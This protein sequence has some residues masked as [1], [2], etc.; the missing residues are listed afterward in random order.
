MSGDLYR[1]QIVLRRQDLHV[2]RPLIALFDLDRAHQIRPPIC[3]FLPY[4]IRV[5]QTCTALGGLFP[6]RCRHNRLL[7]GRTQFVS[8]M[9]YSPRSVLS[10]NWHRIRENAA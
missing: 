5:L 8:V 6:R 2:Y 3:I 9:S 4:L 1:H 7:H 10:K